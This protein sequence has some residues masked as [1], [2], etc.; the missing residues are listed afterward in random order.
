MTADAVEATCLS[1]D[2][3]VPT[4]EPTSTTVIEVTTTA[5]LEATDVTTTG[6]IEGTTINPAP[7]NLTNHESSTYCCATSKSSTVTVTTTHTETSTIT[8]IA[9]TYALSLLGTTSGITGNI[10]TA[11][12]RRACITETTTIFN[13][14]NTLGANKWS[15]AVALGLAG[16]FVL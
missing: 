11:T 2:I 9:A 8:H 13:G 16:I 6:V 7:T 15:L 12:T 4:T 1:T 14:G 10:G 3:D 5:A